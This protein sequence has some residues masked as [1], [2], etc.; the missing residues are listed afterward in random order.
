MAT[1]SGG[2][3]VGLD[4]DAMDVSK[5]L[6][7]DFDTWTA[8]TARFYDDASNY[9]LFQGTGFTHDADGNATGGTVTSVAYVASGGVVLNI[10]GLSA[11]AV[12]VSNLIHAGNSQDL[13]SLLFAGNDTFHGTTFNDVL[14]AYGGNDTLDG[15]AGADTMRGGAGNDTYWVDNTGDKAVEANGQGTDTVNASVSFNMGGSELEKLTLTGAGNINGTGNSIANV[16][17]GNSGNNIFNGLGGNDTLIG[18]A[19][20][21]TMAGGTGNDTYW[22]DNA[23]DKAVEAN[24][25]GTDTVNA[26]VSF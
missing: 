18:G 16:I 6:D 2:T 4:F 7:Y 12:T 23:G 19:G 22:V 17:T 24:G 11:S 3:D 10:G 25:Q 1:V 8:T 20:S 26:S 13:F 14:N 15:G 5:L 21:D 9:T